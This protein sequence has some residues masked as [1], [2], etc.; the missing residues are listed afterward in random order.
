MLGV[1]LY[2]NIF[3]IFAQ[4]IQDMKK[5]VGYIR[6]STNNQDLV[7]QKE[8]IQSF[9]D[10]NGCEVVEFISENKSGTK[11]DREGYK[12]LLTFTN[13]YADAVVMTEVSRFSREEETLN[14]IMN[15]NTIIQNGLKVVFMD[16]DIYEY[17]IYKDKLSASEI[18]E[19]AK[20]FEGAWNERCKIVRRLK[21]GR[22]T[23]FTQFDNGLFG[24]LPFG[25][26]RVINPNY[27][28]TFN[29][30]SFMERDEVESEAVA[31]IYKWVIEGIT[32]KNIALR[33]QSDGI[34][35]HPTSR[36]PEGN[37]FDATTVANIIHNENY[38]GIWHL[39]EVT[40]E[41][42][43]IVTE[44]IWD[45][46]NAALKSNRLRII[47]NNVNFNPLKGIIKCPCGKSMCIINDR[48]YKRYRCAVKKNKY[49]KTICNNGGTGYDNVIRCVWDAVL[50]SAT[51][52]TFVNETTKHIERLKTKIKAYEVDKESRIRIIKNKEQRLDE[53]ASLAFTSTF[54]EK[55]RLQAEKVESEI[56][57][58]NNEVKGL[59]AKINSLK[60]DISDLEAENKINPDR[61][62]SIEQKAEI[63]QQVLSKV[64]YYDVEQHKGYLEVEFKNG[65][66]L[67]Y[68]IMPCRKVLAQLPI[69]FK[70]EDKKIY[71]PIQDE[72]NTTY[73]EYDIIDLYNTY[74]DEIKKRSLL[75]APLFDYIFHKFVMYIK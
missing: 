41:W 4:K 15:M 17:S 10:I 35:N 33:L 60:N 31:N 75:Q 48:K 42:D 73:K 55:I 51:D 13:D 32:L 47:T 62:Y 46:A 37:D 63:F 67:I 30:R 34:R 28:M 12:R 27:K 53:I 57:I 14:P 18:S 69:T 8:L 36:H 70:L 40:K 68:I 72:L 49:D 39:G 5:I 24:R 20:K 22:K 44:E 29:P 21:T 71:V 11:A 2:S 50:C 56:E 64:V 65:M 23:K 58:L 52:I 66:K 9:A 3:R 25:Y 61:E 74:M 26:R 1:A 16:N 7:R 19:L 6:M 38:K 45:K 43:G 59:T 54:L